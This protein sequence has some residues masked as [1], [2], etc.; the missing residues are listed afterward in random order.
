MWD[1]DGDTYDN[2]GFA[3]SGIDDVT[4]DGVP[5]IAV[6]EPG[7]DSLVDGNGAVLVFSG[8]DG[9]F[10]RRLLDPQSATR[11]YLGR[12]V[13]AIE[14]VDG[15]GVGDIVAGSQYG[16][17]VVIFSGLGGQVIRALD[18]PAATSGERL[19]SMLAVIDDLDGDGLQ[20]VIAGAPYADVGGV[21][22]AG[23]AV[24]LS[25]GNGT[26]LLSLENDAD[27]PTNLFGWFVAGIN[28]LSGDGLPELLVGAPYDDAAGVADGGGFAVYALETECDGDGVTPFG[29]DCDDTTNDLWGV[30]TEARMLAFAADN[31]TMSWIAPV[32]SGTGTGWLVYDTLRANSSA[33]FDGGMCLDSAGEDMLTIDSQAPAADAA[34]YYLVRAINPCGA[35]DLGR[36]GIEQRPRTGVSC[37]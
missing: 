8:A 6:G 4:G 20:D 12:S 13:A 35:G 19:G 23:R 26:V 9:S 17:K 37:P 31:E 5:D 14:D 10:V 27:A 21:V 25:V 18:D 30:P 2:L 22:D 36:W 15:D 3:L 32:D 24:V 1:P 29:G 11:S 34:F 16:E 28:D 7:D 33:G